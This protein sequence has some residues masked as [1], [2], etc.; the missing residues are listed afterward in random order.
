[1]LPISWP[2][3]LITYVDDGKGGVKKETENEITKN[4]IIARNP[5][6]ISSTVF[7]NDWLVPKDEWG[8]KYNQVPENSDTFRE[9]KRSGNIKC[10]KIDDHILKL[11]SAEDPNFAT[12]SVSWSKEGMK[13]F[14]GGYL[15]D[16]G[17]GISAID[18]NNTY[19]LAE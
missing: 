1:M 8:K 17:Y 12:I 7:F 15:S 5:T 19:K 18:M 11:L 16:L 6:R 9:Y 3:K 4:H 13:V 2:R 14:K 10:I